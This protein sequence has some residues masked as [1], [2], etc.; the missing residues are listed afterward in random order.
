M[1]ELVG[2]RGFPL[3]IRG[4]LVEA[5]SFSPGARGSLDRSVRLFGRSVKL[6]ARTVGLFARS[7]GLFARSVRPGIRHV[8]LRATSAG[9]RPMGLLAGAVTV[10]FACAARCY[11]QVEQ[12]RQAFPRAAGAEAGGRRGI[13]AWRLAGAAPG[14]RAARCSGN[15]TSNKKAP[16]DRGLFVKS[17]VERMGIEPT[18]ST[19]RT[20]R[21]PS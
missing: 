5:R 21:S 12:W 7:V 15:V 3:G 4:F 17:V 18:T 8:G 10:L 1:G 2:A 14:A 13:A 11:Q 19:M 6:F 9:E 20:W 16:G